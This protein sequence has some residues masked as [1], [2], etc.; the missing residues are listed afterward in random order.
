MHDDP[1]VRMIQS[2]PTRCIR[3]KVERKAP[4]RTIRADVA[5][6]SL[7][8]IDDSVRIKACFSTNESS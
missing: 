8:L 3:A 2:L 6:L 1:L 5:V 7:D 4:L